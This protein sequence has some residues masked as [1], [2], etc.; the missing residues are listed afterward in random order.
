MDNERTGHVHR[1]E[2]VEQVVKV[3]ADPLKSEVST[4]ISGTTFLISVTPRDRFGNYLG[5]GYASSIKATLRS[6]GKLRSETPADPQQIGTYTFEVAGVP[7]GHTPKLDIT[8][9]GV[10]VTK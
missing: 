5:P 8:V 3:R 1:E 4:S 6:P 7:S 10:T 2:R 9:D